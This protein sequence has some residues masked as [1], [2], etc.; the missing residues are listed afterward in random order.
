MACV[1]G[2]ALLGTSYLYKSWK[3]CCCYNLVAP[4]GSPPGEC[5]YPEIHCTQIFVT[6]R[7]GIGYSS[8]CDMS[9]TLRLIS[10]ALKKV[11]M[12]QQNVNHDSCAKLLCTT[13][14][15]YSLQGCCVI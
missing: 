1:G 14:N 7:G 3:Q 6:D 8:S 12:S 5:R 15:I 10:F 11:R 2:G 13:S 4:V 9:K